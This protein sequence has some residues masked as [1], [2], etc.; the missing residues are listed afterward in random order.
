[1][2]KKG[3]KAVKVPDTDPD[4]LLLGF[5]R[6]L[7]LCNARLLA[8]LPPP[9]PPETDPR[10]LLNYSLGYVATGLEACRVVLKQQWP[11]HALPIA[12]PLCEHSVRVL[13]ACRGRWP[14]YWA[15]GAQEYVKRHEKAA[16]FVAPIAARLQSSAFAA[17]KVIARG[18]GMP[19]LATI[20]DDLAADDMNDPQTPENRLGVKVSLRDS[21]EQYHMI[22]PM[23]LHLAAHGNPDTFTADQTKIRRRLSWVLSYVSL[24]VARACHIQCG[25][26]QDPLY[27]AYGWISR[28][29][30]EATEPDPAPVDSYGTLGLPAL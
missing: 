21:R 8:A 17:T 7:N 10:F 11:A 4:R 16:P 30:K 24:A 22:F 18:P 12:R 27:W 9:A 29:R 1:M 2:P 23:D 15:W 19:D 25:W 13:W 28:G 26:R 5:Q 20:L 6:L 3:L 14:R